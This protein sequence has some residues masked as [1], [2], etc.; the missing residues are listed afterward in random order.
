MSELFLA[1]HP[2]NLRCPASIFKGDFMIVSALR[3]FSFFSGVL[4]IK[5]LNI[6]KS[7]GFLKGVLSVFWLLGLF[8]V[9]RGTCPRRATLWI[10]KLHLKIL[11]FAHP[12]SRPPTK[13]LTWLMV[14]APLSVH[15]Q[16]AKQ[17]DLIHHEKILQADESE[18]NVVSHSWNGC[19]QK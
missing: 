14:A 1:V 2:C 15:H 10:T 6:L 3:Q 11:S 12:A 5:Y 18:Q 4:K 16:V 9:S 7:P 19:L 17:K 8:A 13:I